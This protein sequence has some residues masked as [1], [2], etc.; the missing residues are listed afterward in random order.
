MDKT[1]ATGSRIIR[2]H[3][4]IALDVILATDL[5]L[6]LLQ[7]FTNIPMVF[8]LVLGTGLNA[9]QVL[10]WVFW[11][12]HSFAIHI[13]EDTIT[14]PGPRLQKVS[15]PRAE[16]DMWRTESLRAETKAKGYL[17]LWSNDGK[18]IRLF[19][20][21]LGRGHIFRISK[22]LLGDIFEAGKKKYGY[23]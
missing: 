13:T 3:F 19:R 20:K 17:D 1:M 10:F 22:I 6:L 9:L 16:L 18:R 15:F 5:A 8:I 2:P 4:R 23:T 21:V 12:R 11:L 7:T 14:G